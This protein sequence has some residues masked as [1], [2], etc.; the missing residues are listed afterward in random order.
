MMDFEDFAKNC[1]RRVPLHDDPPTSCC[2]KNNT[3]MSIGEPDLTG[4][5]YCAERICEVF[6]GIKYL[7]RQM[8]EDCAGAKETT[9]P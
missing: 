8:L 6:Y 9:K 4:A 7:C 2:R 1:P 3:Y 5:P